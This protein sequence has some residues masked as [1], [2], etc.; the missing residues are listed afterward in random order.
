MLNENKKYDYKRT[1][2][3]SLFDPKSYQKVGATDPISYKVW[4]KY[5]CFMQGFYTRMNNQ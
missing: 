2:R 4:L 5:V 1:I 3:I